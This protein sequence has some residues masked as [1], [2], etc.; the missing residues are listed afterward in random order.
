MGNKHSNL[1]RTVIFPTGK[2][3]SKESLAKEF[4]LFLYNNKITRDQIITIQY[5]I[6]GGGGM[7]ASIFHNIML[8]YEIKQ[9]P[10][11]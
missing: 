11:H 1:I 10:T 4:D 8:V 2:F 6:G 7:S 9:E 5:E 3:K